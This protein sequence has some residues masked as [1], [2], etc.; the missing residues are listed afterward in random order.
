MTTSIV[1]NPFL[2]VKFGPKIE[3]RE[4]KIENE[5]I[6]VDFNHHFF[7]NNE[8]HQICIFLF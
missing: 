7:N 4:E 1:S 8:N 2:L 3:N 6:L 5:L